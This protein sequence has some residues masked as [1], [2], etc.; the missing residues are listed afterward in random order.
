[1]RSPEVEQLITDLRSE[2]PQSGA[3]THEDSTMV[4]LIE[5]TE[6][7]HV[8]NA[9]ES[10]LLLSNQGSIKRLFE[11]LDYPEEVIVELHGIDLDAD[12]MSELESLASTVDE[13]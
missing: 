13:M 12:S 11:A 5:D 3:V 7:R 1:M 6:D 10:R 2:K 9:E 8:F 4:M